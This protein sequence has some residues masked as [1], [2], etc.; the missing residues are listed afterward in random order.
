MDAPK[1]C[2]CRLLEKRLGLKFPTPNEFICGCIGACGRPEIAEFTR[3]GA[4]PL[5]G[6]FVFDA[7]V[8][9][10]CGRD[11]CYCRG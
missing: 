3:R 6:T 2:P 8:C 4:D 5:K 11:L 1:E 7:C 10:H 9:P